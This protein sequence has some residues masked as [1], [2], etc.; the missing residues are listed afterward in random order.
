MLIMSHAYL[1]PD[2]CDLDFN[3]ANTPLSPLNLTT[4]LI[5]PALTNGNSLREISTTTCKV[6]T[7]FLNYA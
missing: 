6:L 3:Y 2:V 5:I 1:G 7:P 4:H